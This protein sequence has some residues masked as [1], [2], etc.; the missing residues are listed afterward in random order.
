MRLHALVHKSFP[1]KGVVPHVR[2]QYTIKSQ[3]V[4]EQGTDASQKRRQSSTVRT[5]RQGGVQ[6]GGVGVGTG[7]VSVR[8]HTVHIT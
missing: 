7:I 8:A 3:Q 6:V 4:N 5:S 2:T 1:G